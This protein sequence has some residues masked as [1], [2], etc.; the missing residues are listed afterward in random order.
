MAVLELDRLLDLLTLP[1]MAWALLW[2]GL[3]IVTVALL[4]MMAT[5]WGQSRTLRKCV[6][7]SLVTHII[8]AT[9]ASTVHVVTPSV[10]PADEPVV[11]LTVVD[12]L[13]DDEQQPRRAPEDVR[14]WERPADSMLPVE[15]DELV[16]PLVP[17]LSTPEPL[18]VDRPSLID[19]VPTGEALAAFE[20]TQPELR[21]LPE[22]APVPNSSEPDTP[23]PIEAPAP[24]RR[25]AADNAQVTA[26]SLER[27]RADTASDDADSP[28]SM[29]GAASALLE[30]PNPLPQ[31]AE[32]PVTPEPEAALAGPADL[33]SRLTSPLEPESAELAPVTNRGRRG[34]RPGGAASREPSASPA[35]LAAAAARSDNAAGHELP[36]MYQLRRSSRRTQWAE[37]L[38]GS[39]ETEAAVEAALRWLADHQ[40]PDG[41]W[42]ASRFGAGR[43]RDEAQID[44]Q[45][46]GANAD[47]GVS[48]LALL[49]MLGAG[50]THRDGEYQETVRRGLSFLITSQA[51]DGNLGGGAETYAFMYCHGM[52]TF[53]LS[54]A[55]AMTGDTRLLSAVE[56]AIAYTVAAQNRTSGG[57]RYRPND[58]GDTSQLGWQLMALKSAE[59]AGLEIPPATRDRMVRFLESVSSGRYRGLASYRPNERV[60]RPMTAE[61][62]VCRQFLGMARN[63]PAAD[64]AGNYLLGQLPGEGPDNLYYWYYATLGLYQLQ[65]SRWE[66]WNEA[67]TSALVASQRADGDQAGS[68]DPD[69]VWGG[70]GGRVYSTAMGALCLEVY[71]RFLPLYSRAESAAE[72]PRRE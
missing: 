69:G 49:A 3:A 21:P 32:T 2:L 29:T 46:A 31:F 10:M 23:E 14:P 4:A 70:H 41:R 56:R 43:G 47:T 7:L 37:Q 20:E 44:R 18:P 39:V 62:L 72:A 59:L 35:A 36:E 11:N 25:E 67:L 64:E 60:S 48:G 63:E 40:E 53:A 27:A 16:R 42:D 58:T 5:R 71:Y 33:P 8:L 6:V 57:W 61:A 15:P 13:G 54:E 66:K 12:V 1:R 65:G 26:P 50:Y 22:E 55:Y 30:Q 52:A 9:Y 68:W 45:G 28:P 38:G 51:A 24:V 19:Y 34:S 17:P